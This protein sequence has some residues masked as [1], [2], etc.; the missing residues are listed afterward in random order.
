MVATLSASSLFPYI[1]DIPMQPSAI[2][3]TD[4]PAPSRRGPACVPGVM[5]SGYRSGSSSATA[6]ELNRRI[7]GSLM[8]LFLFARL[9]A[10]PGKAGAVRQAILDVQ[11]PTRDEPGCLEYHA[12]Q[13]IQ[14]ASEFYIHSRWVDRKA[15]D[16]HLAQTHTTKFADQVEMLIESPLKPVLTSTL[17]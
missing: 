4:G 6:G 5:V 11:G 3:K 2:G 14:D 10:R 13:S 9:Y 1:P 17:R 16:R 7:E 15:F 12:F 8:E